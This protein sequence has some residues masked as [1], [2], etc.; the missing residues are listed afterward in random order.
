MIAN[1]E[2][3]NVLITGGAGFVGSQLAK[4]IVPLA[5]HVYVVDDLSAGSPNAVVSSDKLTFIKDSYYREEVLEDVLPRVQWIFHLACR[6]L[7]LSVTDSLEDFKTNLYGAFAL[8]EK[9]RARC[10]SLQRIVYTSTASVYGNADVRPTPESFYQIT[11]PYSASKFSAE[12]YFDVYARMHGMPVTI[13]RL[14]NVYGPG[15]VASNP[16]CGVVAKF[17]ECLERGDPLPVIGDGLQTR[18]FTY[19]DDALDAIL[20]TAVSPNSVGK[21]Y[22]IGTGIETT[23]LRLAATIGSVA[24]RPDYPI[25]YAPK[26]SIDHIEGR[27]VDS[28]RIRQELS[29]LPKRTLQQGLAE[30]YAWLKQR[31]SGGERT[32]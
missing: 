31:S 19:V 29:W 9:A 8:L 21:L 25:V 22:N 26:R 16:Y 7:S 5:G 10:P 17:F 11:T 28:S 15:Q 30:T 20:L 1:M 23:I 18:D 3:G 4:R 14:S 2:F 32:P 27:S 13:V 6:S 12:H 24:G